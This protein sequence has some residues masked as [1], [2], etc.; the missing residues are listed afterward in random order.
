MRCVLALTLLLLVSGCGGI[1][2]SHSVSP[3]TFFL[4]GLGQVG[5]DSNPEQVVAEES[6]ILVAQVN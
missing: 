1:S 2:G 3:A 5:S 6:D 4:P